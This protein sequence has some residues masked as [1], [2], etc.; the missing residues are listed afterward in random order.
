[1]TNIPNTISLVRLLI[2]VGGFV[3]IFMGY[4]KSSFV[5]L[6]VSVLLDA[7]DGS[8]ARRLNQVT[9]A[10][11]FLDIMV[12]KVVII[13]TFLI[14]GYQLYPVFFYLG[15]LMLL[16]E[17]AIDTLR[18]IAASRQ[19]VIPADGFSKLKGVLFMTA[20]LCAL[21]NRAFLQNV[22]FGQAIEV[23]AILT[24]VLAYITLLRFYLKY[25][26]LCT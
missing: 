26:D 16:R 2:A 12:D 25:R 11:I 9:H 20:M 5:A 4:W 22:W 17:Y 7:V 21:G 6:L 14:I 18:S 10:G 13:C 1:M 23:V 19:I 24:M 15:L 3:L 8:A